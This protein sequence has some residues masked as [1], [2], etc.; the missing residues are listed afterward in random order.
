MQ[1]TSWASLET[2]ST[3]KLV[4]TPRTYYPDTFSPAAIVGV[5]IGSLIFV[6]FIS[7]S[8]YCIRRQRYYYLP[9]YHNYRPT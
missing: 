1:P 3:N 4:T 6:I 7:V 2:S 8:S 9:Y 5:I